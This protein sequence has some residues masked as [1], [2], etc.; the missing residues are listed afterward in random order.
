MALKGSDEIRELLCVGSGKKRYIQ[1]NPKN[2]SS[3]K[4]GAAG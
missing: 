4:I 3:W 2:K 1:K